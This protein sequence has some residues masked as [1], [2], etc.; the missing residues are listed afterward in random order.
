MSLDVLKKSVLNYF[1][2]VLLRVRFRRDIGLSF[3]LLICLFQTVL[4]KLIDD[5]QSARALITVIA[6]LDNNYEPEK[7]FH[8][9]GEEGLA[10]STF[11]YRQIRHN[12]RIDPS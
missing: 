10:H 4:K 5:C 12:E 11:A 3:G 1:V 8:V 2:L 7:V 9:G 6:E